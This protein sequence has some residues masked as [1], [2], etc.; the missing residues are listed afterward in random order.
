MHLDSAVLDGLAQLAGVQIAEVL[1]QYDGPLDG[2][3]RYQGREYWFSALAEWIIRAGE[4]SQPRVYVL[5]AI[6]REQ[7]D[8][9]RA[10]SRR[11]TEFAKG[12]GSRDAWR[13]AW[14]SRSTFDD[15]SPI[16]WFHEDLSND[17]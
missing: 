12:Q 4:Q 3:A 1:E 8:Q 9:V 17:G 5:H 11:F 10:E 2:L 15:A 13:R 14:D 16:G 6:T 7:A